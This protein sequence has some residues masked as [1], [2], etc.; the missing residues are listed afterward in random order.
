VGLELLMLEVAALNKN[1]FI[2]IYK[3]VFIEHLKLYLE[4]DILLQ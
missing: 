4:F 2:H 1:K 3:V